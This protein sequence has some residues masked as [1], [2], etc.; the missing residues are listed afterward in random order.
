MQLFRNLFLICILT[1]LPVLVS[2][3]SDVSGWGQAKW[4]MTHAEVKK[5]Y[6]LGP[7]EPGSAP[8]CK[9][10]KNI[11][12]WEHDFAVALYFDERSA[13]GKLYKVV[14]VHFN[15]FSADAAWLTSIK[16]LL[17][18]KYGNPASFEI[19]GNLKVSRWLKSEGHLKLTTL[20]GQPVMCAI[21][22]VSVRREG[23]K[24]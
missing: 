5:H 14:L 3:E 13:S 20:T 6:E 15:G 22:Y 24:L 8:T 12:I 19:N 23:D 4:G 18:E 16:D 7:W 9:L 10:T 1:F 21:E 17:V 2:A 11:R